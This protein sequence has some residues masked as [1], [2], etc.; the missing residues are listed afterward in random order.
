MY[1]I[2][3]NSV[4]PSS[5]GWQPR[6]MAIAYTIWSDLTDTL[7]TTSTNT[8]AFS[9]LTSL[10]SVEGAMQTVEREKLSMIPP[11]C[12]FCRLQ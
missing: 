12:K 4:L 11:R 10:H 9:L 6:A 5:N 7:G 2:F 8:E 3:S 1:G